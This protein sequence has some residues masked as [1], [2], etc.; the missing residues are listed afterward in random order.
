MPSLRQSPAGKLRLLAT[1]I[2]ILSPTPWSVNVESETPP[3]RMLIVGQILTVP[4]GGLSSAAAAATAA[5][6]S[7]GTA[8]GRSCFRGFLTLM[9]PTWT[10][11]PFGPLPFPPRAA[12]GTARA[13]AVAASANAP[14]PLLCISPP[15]RLCGPRQRN[16]EKEKCKQLLD[17][18]AKEL[19]VRLRHPAEVERLVER[20]VVDAFL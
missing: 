2:S 5:A 16:R 11:S 4:I 9:S 7:T 12:A 10:T 19:A 14:L 13:S 17:A 20:G 3:V 1:Q 6:L 18:A 8:A 15:L